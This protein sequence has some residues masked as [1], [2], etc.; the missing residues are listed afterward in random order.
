MSSLGFIS[1]SL[2]VYLFYILT[3]IFRSSNR[4]MYRLKVFAEPK[5][6]RLQ[7]DASDGGNFNAA[8]DIA[9]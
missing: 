1:L 9:L 7:F 6:T 3:V 5:L 8:S 2:A 4:T